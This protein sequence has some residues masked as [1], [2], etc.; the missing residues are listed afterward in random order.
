MQQ[1]FHAGGRRPW[2]PDLHLHTTASDG[3]LSAQELVL[4]AHAHRLNIIAVTDHD[5]LLGLE[6][7]AQAAQDQGIIFIPGV[8]VSTAGSDEVHVLAYFVHKNMARLDALLS[9]FRQDKDERCLKCLE[10][11]N[12]LGMPL[13][14]DDLQIPQGVAGGRPLIARAMVRKGYAASVPD[15]FE[16]FLAAG[17]PAY[18][19]RKRVDTGEVIAML[20]A[21]GAV[22]VLAHPGLLPYQGEELREKLDY[23]VS[24]GLMGIEAYHPEHDTDTCL[25]WERFARSNWL[26]VTGGSDFHDGSPPHGEM[27]HVLPLWSTA[28]QDVHDLLQKGGMAV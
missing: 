26:L 20:C 10:R 12:E 18:I 17:R 5:T 24:C 22:P 21:E 8:E 27:G 4:R 11:L 28:D 6:D 25:Y 15:A 1:A 14:L 16:H 19:D 3:V 23:W 2:R 13:T 9:S 7:A